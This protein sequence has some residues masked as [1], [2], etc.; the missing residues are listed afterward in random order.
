MMLAGLAV[1]FVGVG[2]NGAARVDRQVGALL[3]RDTGAQQVKVSADDQ[4]ALARHGGASRAIVRRLH[5]DGVV[6][7]EVVVSNGATVLRIAAYDHDGGLVDLLEL[8]ISGPQ[9]ARA[10]IAMLR[11]Q[12]VPD[13]EGLV[14]G[15]GDD[16]PAAD[17][18]P[19]APPPS[20]GRTPA[21]KPAP[22]QQRD[23]D[24]GS[25][26][27]APTVAHADSSADDKA[28]RDGS[29]GSAS[30]GSA[31]DGS[32]TDGSASDGS[33]TDG[34]ATGGAG[35][36]DA[37]LTAT[38]DDDDED[39][40]HLR[41]AVSVGVV[42]RAFSATQAVPSYSSSGVGAIGFTAEVT[43]TRRIGLAVATERTMGMQTATAGGMATTV[44]SR[45][46]ATAAYQLHGGRFAI[47]PV[48]GLGRRS[49]A[50]ESVDPARTPDDHYGYVIAGLNTALS[51]G[52]Y[53]SLTVGGAVEPVVAGAQATA[54]T[55]GSARR[56]GVEGWA[57]LE[58][59][60][61][62]HVFVRASFDYQQFSWAWSSQG[63]LA[64]SSASDAYPSGSLSVGAS[65]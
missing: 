13:L 4:R 51:M 8:P 31:S 36:G 25:D 10:D 37:S 40:L 33:A 21:S 27:A 49:F 26:D 16:A 29:D 34:S 28:A 52:R 63:A 14:G 23:D 55:Y 38:A 58:A 9:L 5:A 32:A 1:V 35:G 20:R 15:S 3:S 7:G 53:V 61:H 46:S 6:A 19:A 2:G 12:L 42:G 59:H 47:A 50:I 22:A 57:A 44:V 41:A 65:Y 43:P 39:T 17:D 24:S 56:L 62:N 64:D 60:P 18:E 54:M 48:V 11:T 45:W 30:D